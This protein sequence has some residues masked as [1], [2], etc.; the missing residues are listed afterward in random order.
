MNLQKLEIKEFLPFKQG[1]DG[2][3]PSILTKKKTLNIFQGLFLFNSY[4]SRARTSIKKISHFTF[5]ISH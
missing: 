4:V 5:H 2:S 3:I 1:V